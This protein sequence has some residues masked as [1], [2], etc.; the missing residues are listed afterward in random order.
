MRLGAAVG[1]S[2]ET[3]DGTSVGFALN[4]AFVSPGSVGIAVDGCSEGTGLG[5]VVGCRLGTSVG[6]AVGLSVG[7][8]VGVCDGCSDGHA[9]GRRLG[10][11]VGTGE[12][13]DCD[14][15]SVGD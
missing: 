10:C 6:Y 9:L 1:W 13:G 14:G 4:G 2:V 15:G 7:D 3:G 8:F 5:Y 11:S 12:V